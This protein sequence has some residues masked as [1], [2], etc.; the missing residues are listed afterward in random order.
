MPLHL[1]GGAYVPALRW[2]SNQMSFVITAQGTNGTVEQPVQLQQV[3]IDFWN[4]RTGWCCLGA[5]QAPQWKLDDDLAV[6]GPNP[7]PAQ[8]Y[9]RAFLVNTYNSQ[10]FQGESVRQWGET[11]V[12]AGMGIQQAYTEFEAQRAQHQ[13]NEVPI[14]QMNGATNHG[15]FNVPNLS[16][17]GW[18]PRPP[19]LM[20][21]S[22]EPGMSALAHQQSPATPQ[23]PQAQ[24]APT[25]PPTFPAQQPPQQAFNGPAAVPQ[26]QGNGPNLF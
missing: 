8:E 6:P 15:Q 10:I 7:N 23:V 26:P 25:Q 5:G 21:Q 16:V 9:K 2:K 11:G 14:I 24:A 18:A 12:G 3:L 1:G 20:D 13:R 4:I 17:V 19:E 22:P